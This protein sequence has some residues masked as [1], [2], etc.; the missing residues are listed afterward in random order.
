MLVRWKDRTKMYYPVTYVDVCTLSTL[1]QCFL[2]LF[3]SS[4][5]PVYHL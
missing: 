1:I 5:S 2:S 3:T 4:L